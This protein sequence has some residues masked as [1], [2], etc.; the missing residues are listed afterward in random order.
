MRWLTFQGPDGPRL[1]LVKGSGVIDVGARGGAPWRSLREALAA[2]VLGRA[3]DEFG[4][5]SADL[6]LAGL[7]FA[8]V[9]PDPEKII[10]VGVN[11]EGHRVETGRDRTEHPVLFTRFA[12]SQ[13]GHGR[14]LVRPRVSA[15]LDYEGELAVVIGRRGR[16]VAR[17]EAL[18][19]VAGYAC[20]NDAS[21]RDWQRHTHQFTPGK[22]FVGTGAFGPFLVGADEVPDPAALLLTTRVNGAEVQRAST[23]ELIFDVPALIAYCS[24]FTELAPGDVIVTGT[25]SGVGHKRTPPLYLKAGDVVEVEIAGVGLLRNPVVDEA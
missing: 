7:E 18:G 11:Y 14:P 13:V 1:G 15:Q 4:A 6:E 21:V 23:S 2:G 5:L 17:G 12:N 9:V 20:Y 16:H 19:L 10:C 25:P 24:T 22:N 8:P 3:G